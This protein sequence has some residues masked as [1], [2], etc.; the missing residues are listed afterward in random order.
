MKYKILHY[1][2]TFNIAMLFYLLTLYVSLTVFGQSVLS[3]A[4]TTILFIVLIKFKVIVFSS[5][6][7]KRR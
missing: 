7:L 2:A 3:L 5:N 1:V 6:W 4:I